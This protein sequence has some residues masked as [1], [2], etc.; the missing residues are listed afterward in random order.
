MSFLGNGV[1]R[2]MI[3]PGQISPGA[4]GYPQLDSTVTP[5]HVG[6]NRII[7]GDFRIKQY[8]NAVVAGGKVYGPFDRFFGNSTSNSGTITVSAGTITYGGVVKPAI[9]QTVTTTFSSAVSFSGIS[10]QIEGY[11]CADMLG[12]PVVVSFIFNTNVSGTYSVTLRDGSQTYS[13]ISTFVAV[14]N[15]PQKVTI[16]FNAI[17]T[18]ASVPN[19]N[20]IGLQINVGYVD[21]T[22]SNLTSTLNSWLPAN[23][24]GATTSTN[25]LTAA[26]NFIA[27]TEL[28]F[29]VGSVATPFERR[30]YGQELALCQRYYWASTLQI[31][32]TM[33]C[34]GT[35]NASTGY[36]AFPTQMRAS[37]S[38]AYISGSFTLQP[39]GASVSSFTLSATLNGFFLSA[40]ASGLTPGYAYQMVG[41]SGLFANAEL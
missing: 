32:G 18:A 21:T 3:M 17:P 35:V 5:A 40:V 1:G 16:P 38:V 9:V 11:N 13:C 31:V 7:N 29:E 10:Q 36:L 27:L 14:A 6:K 2:Q 34:N 37:P 30:S 15:I 41:G 19:S 26:N 23:F 4:V 20:V 33:I 22:G 28:Q 24:A 25:W 39:G 8:G 12:Q